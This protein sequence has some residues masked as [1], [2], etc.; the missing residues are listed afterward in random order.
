MTTS[1]PLKFVGNVYSDAAFSSQPRKFFFATQDPKIGVN[2]F[3]TT[4]SHKV[5]Y[6]GQ[7][8]DVRI[9]DAGAGLEKRLTEMVSKD[10][11]DVLVAKGGATKSIR[12]VEV[13]VVYVRSEDEENPDAEA[14]IVGPDYDA[15]VYL[16]SKEH[17]NRVFIGNA[18]RT[19][20]I[21]VVEQFGEF[22]PIHF[23]TDYVLG[24]KAGHAV[25]TGRSG[26]A[27]K[28]SYMTFMIN[29]LLQSA[30][31]QNLKV[32][33][34][35]FNVKDD[36][37]LLLKES[38]CKSLELTDK[39]RK[40]YETMGIEPEFSGRVRNF[41]LANFKSVVKNGMMK[42]GADFDPQQD[43]Q[44]LR[45]QSNGKINL[46]MTPVFFTKN[47]IGNDDIAGESTSGAVVSLTDFFFEGL[48]H[49][50][51]GNFSSLCS[52]VNDQ[53]D[54]I[55]REKPSATIREILAEL[56]TFVG[57]LARSERG[58]DEKASI[59][60]EIAQ[61]MRDY[62]YRFEKYYGG[63]VAFDFD[64]EYPHE[65][66]WSEIKANDVWVFDVA[67]GHIGEHSRAVMIKY[68]LNEV[69]KVLDNRENRKEEERL[70]AIVICLDEINRYVASGDSDNGFKEL[71]I[72]IARAWRSKGGILIGAGQILSELD[73]QFT[74]N[75]ATKIVGQS[76]VSELS[77][78]AYGDLPKNLREEAKYLPHGKKIIVH[79]G[80]N[81]VATLIHFPRPLS[82]IN[83]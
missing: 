68:V 19:F 32:A 78:K 27:A 81:N 44:P 15:S 12:L 61:K 53:F 48:R 9:I 20:P 80:W 33:T 23:H 51:A 65:K 1:T 83:D 46:K 42:V 64:C 6:I 56:R 3:V 75:M 34:I 31:K 25:L 71:M 18:K 49:D 70:D 14:P 5:R 55:K 57:S 35:M 41:G 62:L 36:D 58:S 38:D 54:K 26:V 59:T 7:I 82:S 40:M 60:P 74:S 21:G 30:K 63:M 29:S 22:M 52:R 50:K 72:D 13:S 11:P 47:D 37:L 76:D 17:I 4:V 24:R 28:T 69:K 39:E 2:H 77:D 43:V 45:T 79:A 8:T 16:A 10:L 66:L 67:E 73:H